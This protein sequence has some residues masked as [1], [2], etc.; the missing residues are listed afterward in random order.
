MDGLVIVVSDDELNAVNAKQRNVIQWFRHHI[1]TALT[2]TQ[3]VY[4]PIFT[5]RVEKGN[6]NMST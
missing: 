6:G 3:R 2:Q 1:Q 5:Q 4:R